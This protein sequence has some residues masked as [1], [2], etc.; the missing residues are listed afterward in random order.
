MISKAQGG[1]S[2]PWE[3]QDPVNKQTFTPL[4]NTMSHHVYRQSQMTMNPSWPNYIE[5]AFVKKCSTRKS[6]HHITFLSEFHNKMSLH[7]MVRWSIFLII[8]N[9]EFLFFIIKAPCHY[10]ERMN[11]KFFFPHKTPEIFALRILLDYLFLDIHEA[12]NVTVTIIK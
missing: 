7:V 6:G 2:L 11:S 1:I 4:G 9:H 8:W 12:N 3:I 5:K 10:R